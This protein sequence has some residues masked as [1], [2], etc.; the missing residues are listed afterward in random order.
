MDGQT[1]GA[2]EE[3]GCINGEIYL[4]YCFIFTVVMVFSVKSNR[5]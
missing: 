2:G 4:L 1:G 5:V 3:E